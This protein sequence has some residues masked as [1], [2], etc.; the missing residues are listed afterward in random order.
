MVLKATFE[1]DEITLSREGMNTSVRL[2]AMTWWKAGAFGAGVRKNNAQTVVDNVPVALGFIDC[3][4]ASP[5]FQYR[6][7]GRR[8]TSL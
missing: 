1:K 5:V 8:S 3:S 6:N 7:G 4:L 2:P